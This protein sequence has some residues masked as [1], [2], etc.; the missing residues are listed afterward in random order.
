MTKKVLFILLF[1]FTFCSFT[2]FADN[3]P[4]LHLT[5]K[6]VSDYGSAKYG[7]TDNSGK[8]KID[9]IYDYAEEFSEGLALVMKNRRVYFINEAGFAVFNSKT[10]IHKYIEGFRDGRA[11]VRIDDKYGYINKN[12]YVII[13]AIYDDASS[14]KE[15]KAAVCKNNKYGYIDTN[16]KTV[17]GFS[18]DSANSFSNGIAR[19]SKNNKYGFIDSDGKKLT[20]FIYEKT[21]AFS[22][23]LCPVKIDGK[24]TFIDI[25]GD[26]L[27]PPVFDWASDFSDG[28]ATVS[29]DEKFGYINTKGELVISPNYS[30]LSQFCDGYLI[31]SKLNKYSYELFGVIDENESVHIPFIYNSITYLSDNLFLVKQDSGFGVI[32]NKNTCVLESAYDSITRDGNILTARKGKDIYTFDIN[33]IKPQKTSPTTLKVL[34]FFPSE[35]FQ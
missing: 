3:A 24:Y 4:K 28:L 1:I 11:L 35:E 2:I 25:N 29:Y 9:Y 7:Y 23:G 30:S 12:G 17:I 34:K 10:S 19:I 13:P 26:F 33:D 31:C 32:N 14:F 5:Y 18:Y 15:G 27:L 16:G 21:G 8:L 6:V 22:L 20:P